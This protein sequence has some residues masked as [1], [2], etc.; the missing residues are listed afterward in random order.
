MNDL[1]PL[2]NFSALDDWLIAAPQWQPFRPQAA[3]EPH[4]V[5]LTDSA[6]S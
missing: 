2:E 6:A 4:A 1:A 3:S 5:E